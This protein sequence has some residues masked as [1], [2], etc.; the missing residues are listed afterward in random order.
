MNAFEQ[1]NKEAEEFGITEE[2]NVKPLKQ[3]AFAR[4]QSEQMKQI[5]NRL[6]FDLTMT[7]VRMAGTKDEDSKAA[8][9]AKVTEYSQQLRQT[10]DGLKTALQLVKELESVVAGA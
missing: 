10:R 6:L 7:K 9:N 1:Y 2:L 8:Y 5:V 3:L 4:E